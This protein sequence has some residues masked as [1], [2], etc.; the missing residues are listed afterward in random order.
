M[1]I[2]NKIKNRIDKTWQPRVN[3]GSLQ[4]H[5]DVDSIDMTKGDWLVLSRTRHMLTDIEESLY[6]QGLYYKNKYKRTNEQGLHEAATAWEFLRQG[7]LITYKQ[8]E[9]IS[10]YMGPKHWHAEKNKRYG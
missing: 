10:K 1:G 4:R 5:F 6:R 8:V 3:E 7:Q 2:I 9:S